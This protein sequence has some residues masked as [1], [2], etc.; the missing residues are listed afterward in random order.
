M[1]ENADFKDKNQELEHTI[2]QLQCET[3]TISKIIYKSFGKKS[4]LDTLKS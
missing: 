2:M 4:N 3:D 1:Q